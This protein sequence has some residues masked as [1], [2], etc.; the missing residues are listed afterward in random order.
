MPDEPKPSYLDV[1]STVLARIF[2]RQIRR[3]AES[4]DQLLAVLEMLPQ[5]E[6]C[7]L[8]LGASAIRAS[9]GSRP[10]T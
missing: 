3:R 2:C 4:A 10:S 7:W 9:C 5:P 6:D 1:E 8:E